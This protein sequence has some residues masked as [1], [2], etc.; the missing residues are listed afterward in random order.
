MLIGIEATRANKPTKTGV[1]WYAWHVIQE[2]KKK[3]VDDGHSWILYGNHALQGGLEHLPNN[4]FESR[5]HWPLPYGWTQLR[6]SWEMIR[7]PPD[8]LFLP[9]STM[10]RVT[11]KKIVVTIHDV[12]FRRFPQLYKARQVHIH[13]RAMKEAVRR[14][15]R[16]ITV[17][18]F[19]AQE[20]VATYGID[21]A[22][23]AITP[24]GVDHGLY[25][26]IADLAAIERALHRYRLARPFFVAIGRLEAK[27]NL[28]NLVRAFGRFKAEQGVGDPH[29]LILVGVPGYGVEEIRK[30]I[31]SSG[32]ASS[33]RELGYVPE[34]DLPAILNAAEALI[35]P[36]WYE[37]FGIPPLMAMASGCPVLAS[38]AGSLPE[39]I[40]PDAGVY[41]APE[42]VHGCAEAMERLVAED[43]LRERLRTA[44]IVRAASYTWERTA[45][46]TLPVLTE[47]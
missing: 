14:A 9:G 3:T 39:V 42:D 1:E 8:V 43:G 19:S 37:G 36:S 23:I 17:S 45:A 13:E 38:T 41:F 24:N 40:G 26:P 32:A 30:A 31:A 4:W 11:P 5:M 12:G 15:T 34:G 46:A 22:R 20:L 33:I 7:R 18:E 2:L 10:P 28:V 29:T 35:H 25:R 21:P 47:W 44:G 6:L 16:I 27:K